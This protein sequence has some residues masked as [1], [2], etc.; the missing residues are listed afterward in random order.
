MKLIPHRLTGDVFTGYSEFVSIWYRSRSPHRNSALPP[1]CNH[2]RCASTHFGENQLA[3]GSI[4]ISPLTT[5]HPPI[6]Q[7]RSVR[8]STWCYPSF[9]L[10]MVRSPG[11]GSTNCDFFGRPFRTRFRF[12]CGRCIDLN[13]PQPVSRRLILQQAHGQTLNRPPI[14]C[15]L[16]VSCSISLPLLGFFSPFPRG[17]GSLSV[18]Q[19][20][21]ALRGGP[22]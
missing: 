12:G 6:F 1:S 13:L 20:Y 19:E 2:H 5:P 16:R 3:P 4:G 10:D 11:F 17:T 9:I 15:R 22:R 21:L 18:T 7:H 14:A 8:T